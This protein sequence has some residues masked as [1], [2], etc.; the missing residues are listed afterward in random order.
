MAATF[1]QSQRA[2]DQLLDQAE[3]QVGTAA[4][5]NIEL[6][7]AVVNQQVDR[8]ENLYGQ[9]NTY[10][11]LASTSLSSARQEISDAARQA[12]IPEELQSVQA[13]S[14]RATVVDN[15]IGSI[16]NS[17]NASI[18]AL[19]RVRYDIENNIPVPPANSE[20]R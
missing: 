7:A 17:A 10:L 20:R 12:S 9:V 8:A 3:K 1:V 16:R 14:A 2:A 6:G 18:A 13:L 15:Q 4:R 11:G 5:L 19:E